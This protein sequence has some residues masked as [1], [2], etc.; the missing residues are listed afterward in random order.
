MGC[1][2]YAYYNRNLNVYCPAGYNYSNSS[3]CSYGWVVFGWWVLGMTIFTLLMCMICAA[4][5]RRMQQAMQ[6]RENMGMMN[7]QRP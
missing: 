3:C 4:R 1:E 2:N 5:R 6:Y 7:Q